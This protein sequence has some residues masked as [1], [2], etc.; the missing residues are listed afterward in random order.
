[1]RVAT[2]AKQ[3]YKGELLTVKQWEKK[4]FKPKEGEK[5]ERMCGNQ[6]SCGSGNSKRFSYDYYYDYQ[7][8]PITEELRNG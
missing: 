4:G 3:A 6:N 7:V 5:P 8:E 1:M 2:L